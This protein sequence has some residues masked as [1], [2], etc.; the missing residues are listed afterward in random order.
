[1]PV[2]E[3]DIE[4]PFGKFTLTAAK[5]IGLDG[6]TAVFGAS[7]SGKTTLLNILGGLDS[8]TAGKVIVGKTNLLT[9][10]GR[11]LVKYR[12]EDVGFVWQQTGRNGRAAMLRY[13]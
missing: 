4:R 3:I 10:S 5:E 1:M 8:P 7:G 13:T 6:I 2:L 12:R 11:G 9:V